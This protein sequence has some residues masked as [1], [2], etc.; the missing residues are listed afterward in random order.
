MRRGQLG[1]NILELTMTLA[2]LGALGSFTVPAF[3]GYTERA[4]INRAIGEISR[5]SIE[6]NRWRTNTESESY[7]ES[8]EAAGISVGTDPWGNAYNYQR[9]AGSDIDQQRSDSNLHPLN[10][11]FDLFSNGPDGQS[12]KQLNGVFARDD[13]VRADNGTFVGKAESY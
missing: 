10:S 3:N 7:P 1:V 6:I 11:D 9:I 4:R 5:I 13:I 12:E 8:L 2:L